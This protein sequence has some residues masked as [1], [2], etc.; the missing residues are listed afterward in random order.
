[1]NQHLKRY[2]EFG[3][4]SLDTGKRLLVHNGEPVPLAPKILETLL[5]LVENRTLTPPRNILPMG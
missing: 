1:M 4:F 5:V 2:Y 3:P